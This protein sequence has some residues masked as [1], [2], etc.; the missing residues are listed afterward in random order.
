[1]VVADLKCYWSKQNKTEEVNRRNF[2]KYKNIANAYKSR[3]GKTELITIML[4]TAGPVPMSALKAI[5]DLGIKSNQAASVL[6][7]MMVQVIKGNAKIC[8]CAAISPEEP[9]QG[10]HSLEVDQVLEDLELPTQ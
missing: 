9:A 2:D 5:K 3:Y 7:N 4:P 10:L 6:R 1:M 8:G